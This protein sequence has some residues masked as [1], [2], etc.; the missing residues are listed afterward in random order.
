M[1]VEE[2]TVETDIRI[3][4]D[5]WL[6]VE[7]EIERS[8][9]NQIDTAL[10]IASP[11]PDENP[12]SIPQY[13]DVVTID[14]GSLR[15]NSSDEI[16]RLYTGRVTN[17]RNK[18]TGTWKIRCSNAMLD[19]TNEQIDISQV[20]QGRV[21]ENVREI[22]NIVGFDVDI[23]LDDDP[24]YYKLTGGDEYVKMH[25]KKQFENTDIQVS[26]DRQSAKA[27]FLLDTLAELSNAAWWV[28]RTNTVIFG[29]TDTTVHK[30]DA[31]YNH[32][33]DTDA[34]KQTPPYRSV[35]VIGDEVV[36]QSGWENRRLIS[37]NATTVGLN[38]PSASTAGTP[39][40][41][42]QI[43]ETNFEATL[44][45]PTFTYKSKE[46]KTYRQAEHVA[47]KILNNLQEQQAGGWVEMAGRS[48][49]EVFDIIEMPDSFG[50]TNRIDGQIRQ[51][52]PAAYLVQKITHR[53]NDSDGFITRIESGGLAGRYASSTVTESDEVEEWEV[54]DGESVGRTGDAARTGLTQ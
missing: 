41:R 17:R 37:E 20:Q 24:N 18:N 44:Q 5:R 38:L 32:V 23:R 39:P 40:L 4:G 2:E 22:S 10:M 51:I 15:D 7:L 27:S 30:L 48:N 33:V 16:R 25:T 11:D 13:D 12:D 52:P 50:T 31:P 49:I 53:M 43:Q 14:A 34:G 8:R 47:S 19:I 1:V 46:I 9:Y 36:S 28:D 29:P 42:E 45:K 6:P 26:F 54:D 21:S 3:D 35:R